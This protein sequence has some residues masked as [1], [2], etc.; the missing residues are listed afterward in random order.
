MVHSA[1][2]LLREVLG[3]LM[4]WAPTHIDV[5]E[6]ERCVTGLPGVEAVHDLHIWTISSGRVALAGHV[7]CQEE[8]D[9][10]KLLQEVTDLLHDRFGIE[11]STVQVETSDFDE[12]VMDEFQGKTGEKTFG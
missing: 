4:E 12:P 10:A 1:W 7:V 2:L 3:V 6:V 9:P 11:H 5:S 8:R